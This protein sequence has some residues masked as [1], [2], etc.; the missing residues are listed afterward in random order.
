M[1][2]NIKHRLILIIL[3]LILLIA[4]VLTLPIH[5]GNVNS[6]GVLTSSR[7]NKYEDFQY[8]TPISNIKDLGSKV[9][10]SGS[11]DVFNTYRDNAN[12][13]KK[14][15]GNNLYKIPADKY[16]FPLQIII[17]NPDC[18]DCKKAQK[19]IVSG[20]KREFDLGSKVNV[21]VVPINHQ[22][23]PGWLKKIFQSKFNKSRMETPT[24]LNL[25][26]VP[27]SKTNWQWYVISEYSGT[28]TLEIQRVM[29][30][31]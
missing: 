4:I 19:D 24:I 13:S 26:L 23:V 11:E 27:R 2:S 17:Y 12:A 15:F 3:L 9:K 20:L 25:R 10:N 6:S 28:D 30:I 5:F 31:F 8:S 22:N 18:I 29:R 16:P 1:K 7:G 14:K 21:V